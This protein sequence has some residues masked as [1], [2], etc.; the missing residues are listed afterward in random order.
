MNI[1]T[2]I[3]ITSK[4]WFMEPVQA[5][6]WAD[7]FC[8]LVSGGVPSIDKRWLA[9]S[10]SGTDNA[11]IFNVD[12]KG[13]VNRDG[14]IQVFKMQGPIAKYDYCGD[15]GS[16]SWAQHL[17]AANAD[18]K[19][20]GIILMIDS[21]G[22]QVDGTEILANAVKNSQKPVVVYVNSLMAS[23]A[24]WI[25]SAANEIIADGSNN[26]LNAKI[27]S[28]G[29]MAMFNKSVI[30]K[31]DNG[32]YD[33]SNGKE[34][35]L[36][37]FANDSTDKWGDYINV[38]NGNIDALKAELSGLNNT[39]LSAVK[40]N[41]PNLTLD[42]ENVLTGKTYNANEAL[43]YGLIDKIGSFQDAVKS[44]TKLFKS[45]TPKQTM[46]K[47]TVAFGAIN[48]LLAE[49]QQIAVVDNGFLLSE[50]ALNKINAQLEG[51]STSIAS[52]ND[53][54]AALETEKTTLT[55]DKQDLTASNASL[56]QNLA[57]EKAK[58]AGLEEASKNFF[59]GNQGGAGDN[60]AHEQ[61]DAKAKSAKY[62]HNQT[63]DE[64]LK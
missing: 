50:E 34:N 48:A 28:I 51:N 22:G 19:I 41:R 58:V 8:M 54:L 64:I 3:G 10:S 53:Q 15:P 40:A 23:A 12:T 36:L 33:L 47:N 6:A 57:D 44:V 31:N 63:A 49:D 25:G 27:G 4:P 21:P 32:S 14:E 24:Y 30:T 60:G 5:Q 46:S 55:A 35:M 45:Q 13:N 18:N 62:K 43:K 38:M 61:D 39:F 17:E 37:V 16:I 56:T 42:K 20:K 11:P 26:G 9:Q 29:T 2:L 52:L 59:G 1:K 7:S